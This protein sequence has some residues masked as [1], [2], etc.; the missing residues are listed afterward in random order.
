[1]AQSAA[2]RG[3]LPT[4]SSSIVELD[5]SPI[6]R[7]ANLAATI[8][9]ALR[10]ELGE[11]D[12]R[13]PAHIR[14][15]AQRVV[16]NELIPYTP[17]QGIGAL[18]EQIARKL[19]E[20]NGLKVSPD[21]IVCGTGGIGVIAAAMASVVERGD[22]VLLPDPGWPNYA[23]ML[24]W[25]GARPVYYQCPA[26]LD[27][28]PDL[29]HLR[30]SITNRSRAVV[31]N[32]PNN[33]TGAIYSK[34][35]LEAIAELAIQ[36]NLWL[37]SDECYD[38]I[39]FVGGGGPYQCLATIT[40]D[41]RVIS[42]FTFS[43][44]YAMTGWRIGY[45]TGP[46][47]VIECMTKVLQ[48]NSSCPSYISQRAAEAAL[49][50]P[51]DEVARMV[52]VYRRRR[53]L[54]V[55]LLRNTPSFVSEPAGAFYILANIGQSGVRSTEFAISLLRAKGVAL[56]PGDAFGHVSGEMVRIS[57]ASADVDLQKGISDLLVT[58][59]RGS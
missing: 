35:S 55:G 15:A 36:R 23:M 41:A 3:S 56:A 49:D 33:P 21:A 27:F 7:I 53:D 20:V 48:S 14:A 28:L 59:A 31:V 13:T 42:C 43:K 37:I 17:T 5:A 25:L 6:R 47:P 57:L 11:P 45:A 50:G 4:P 29:E 54:A 32:S 46:K 24:A 18:R 1:M 30:S 2:P 19:W 8:P 34:S 38:Q 58:L 39:R 44:T 12:F 26:E 22:E 52:Q 9:G 16:A 51:Q 40:E 10:L